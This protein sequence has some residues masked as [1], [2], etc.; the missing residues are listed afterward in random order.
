[1]QRMRRREEK[2]TKDENEN[3]FFWLNCTKFGLI[4]LLRSNFD[5]NLQKIAA[6]IVELSGFMR[7]YGRRNEMKEKSVTHKEDSHNQRE[8]YILDFHVGAVR[9]I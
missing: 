8:N 9:I 1:M 4:S 7:H 2:S 3:T 5:N 6:V